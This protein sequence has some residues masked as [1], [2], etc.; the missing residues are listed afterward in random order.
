LI[1]FRVV[2]DGPEAFRFALSRLAEAAFSLHVLA[3]PKHHPVQHAWIRRARSLSTA[4][5][6]EIRAFE[7]L[8]HDA[9]PNCVLPA[10]PEELPSFEAELAQLERLD[11]ATI[12]YEIAQPLFFYLHA[13]AGGPEALERPD[14]RER[15]LWAAASHGPESRRVGELIYDDPLELRERFTAFLARYWAEGF[16]EEWAR[17]EPQLRAAAERT[18]GRIEEDGI[19]PVV[20][21]LQPPLVVDRDRRA[22]GRPS[23]HEHE[24]SVDPE[25]PLLLVPS[26]HVWPHARVNC[27]EPWPLTLAFPA[28]F[29][30]SRARRERPPADL[31]T[32][33]RALADPTRLQALRLLAEQPRTTEELAPLVGISEAGLSKHLRALSRARL[34]RHRRQGYY[35]LYELDRERLSGLGGDLVE[36][37]ESGGATNAAAAAFR[38]APRGPGT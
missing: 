28:V 25:H 26:V 7:S 29:V 16:A 6:R 19:W 9:L 34:V 5:K 33:L 35:V 14:V 15:V 27:D 11:P 10:R 4:L 18:R 21:E 22:I 3:K 1:T 17:V 20:E 2:H 31:V 12:A 24:V 23:G 37:V 8:F 30:S 38:R 36:F 13:Q 32:T